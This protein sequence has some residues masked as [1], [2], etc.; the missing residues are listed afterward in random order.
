GAPPRRTK[1][2]K[3][4]RMKNSVRRSKVQRVSWGL[5]LGLAACSAE[6]GQA[7]APEPL[8]R[9]QKALNFDAA[10]ATCSDDPR[11]ELGLV[12][13][14]VCVGAELFFRDDFGGNGRSCASCHPA[15][16]NYTIDAEF[17]AALP[18]DDPLFVAETPGPL[19][20]LEIPDLLRDFGLILENVDG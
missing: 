1:N 6:P 9:A 18:I 5:W 13:Q 15:D 8:G 17:I 19:A 10:T 20:G 3:G 2:G 11:V 12:S 7:G 4:R 14:S 16:N